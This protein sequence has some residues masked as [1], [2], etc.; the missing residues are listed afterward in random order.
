MTCV[1]VSSDGSVANIQRVESDLSPSGR[2]QRGGVEG[3]CRCDDRRVRGPGPGK[4]SARAVIMRRVMSPMRTWLADSGTLIVYGV[5]RSKLVIWLHGCA[6]A[7]RTQSP[8]PQARK[9]LSQEELADR[10]NIH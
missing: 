5:E 3:G 9:G 6:G 1:A 10:A 7:G 4:T 8:K 2:D